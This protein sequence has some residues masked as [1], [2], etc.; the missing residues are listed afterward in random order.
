MGSV[1]ISSGTVVMSSMPRPVQYQKTPCWMEG[2]ATQILL[3]SARTFADLCQSVLTSHGLIGSAFCFIA[4]SLQILV[5]AVSGER[6]VI[7][8]LVLAISSDRQFTDTCTC[9]IR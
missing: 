6:Q 2:F 3:S 8:T 9:C 7:D 5:L 1:P 4:A